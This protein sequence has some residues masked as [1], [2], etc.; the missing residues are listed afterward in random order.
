[1]TSAAL[2]GCLAALDIGVTSP[3]RSGAGADCCEAM[4]RRKVQ[5]YSPYLAEMAAAELFYRPMVWSAFGREH[6]QTSV[7]L[8]TLARSAARRRGLRDHRLLLRRARAA[9]GVQLVCRA[10]RMTRACL[11]TLPAEGEGADLF[12]DGASRFC[13]PERR[14]VR[15]VD[16]D[17]D[18]AGAA[19][20]PAAGGGGAPRC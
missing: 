20:P 16:G 19:A 5:E 13:A 4:H 3:D 15:I 2:L 18:A 14:T 6:P 7:T 10:V 9:I 1:M 17:A 11:E 12:S 8:E